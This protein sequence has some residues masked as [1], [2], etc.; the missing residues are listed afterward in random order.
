[1]RY[2]NKINQ[3]FIAQS[4]KPSDAFVNYILGE[5]NIGRRTK[6]LVEVF[7]E[8]AKTSLKNLISDNKRIINYDNNL[9]TDTTE[10]PITMTQIELE[11]FYILKSLLRKV[12]D[13][14][15]ITFIDNGIF[16]TVILDNNPEKW[17]SKVYMKNKREISLPSNN[18][19]GEITYDFESIN[20]LYELDNQIL[21]IAKAYIN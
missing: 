3:L 7:R 5:M 1:M 19:E 11:S 20:D 4:K 12:I 2:L 8:Y 17:I 18:D 15:N 21:D 9:D 6:S 14:N 16:F 10:N 13:P